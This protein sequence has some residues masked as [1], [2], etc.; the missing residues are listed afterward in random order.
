MRRID[1][2]T[3]GLDPF[4]HSEFK[5]VCKERKIQMKD[6]LITALTDFITKQKRNDR[7]N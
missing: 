2:K 3:I 6:A 5:V 1:E 4:I 7:T